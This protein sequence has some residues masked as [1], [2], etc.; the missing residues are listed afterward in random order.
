MLQAGYLETC[1]K[2][3]KELPRV[4]R[5]GPWREGIEEGRGRAGDCCFSLCKRFD[6]LNNIDVGL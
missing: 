1:G 3:Q 5:G 4:E 2:Q 6:F